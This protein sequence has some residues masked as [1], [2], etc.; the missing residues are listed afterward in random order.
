MH[1]SYPCSAA[2]RAVAAPMPR[3]PPVTS[4]YPL[5]EAMPRSLPDQSLDVSEVASVATRTVVR[6]QRGRGGGSVAVVVAFVL[7]AVA[8][9]AADLTT[10]PHAAVHVRV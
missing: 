8:E 9:L 7:V 1:T 3:L 6:T 4:T 5:G 10:R 2:S